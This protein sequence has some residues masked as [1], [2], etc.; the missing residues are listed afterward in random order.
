MIGRTRALSP[1]LSPRPDAAATS[2]GDP[3]VVLVPGLALDERDWSGVRPLLGRPSAVV[4][5]PALGTRPPR[6]A[7][8]RVEALA[9][10]L[11]QALNRVAPEH[12][13]V[14]V[15]HSASCPVVVEAARRDRRVAGLVLVGPITDS[16]SRGWPH[17]LGRWTRTAVHERVWEVPMLLPQYTR[18]GLLRSVLGGMD[19]M[20]WF[21]TEV[22][23]AD[24]EVPVT[25]VRG[26]H[27]RIAPADWAAAL[28]RGPV[29]RVVTLAGGA[30]MVPLTHPAEVAD[31]IVA[32]TGDAAARNHR[33]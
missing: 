13:A 28:T 12:R 5:L 11:L 33:L 27:D 10:Q 9:G 23:L 1:A 17:V 29:R 15:G 4:R 18:M 16:R 25:V 30:H 26:E 3:V 19:Q 6:S 14:L 31:A 24:V 21:R 20:R 8:L 2:P 32:T 7:D 22:A